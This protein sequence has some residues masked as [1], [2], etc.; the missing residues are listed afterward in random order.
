MELAEIER[1]LVDLHQAINL[2]PTLERA[3]EIGDLLI[4]AKEQIP[5]GE[6]WPWLKLHGLRPRTAW[7]YVSVARHRLANPWPATDLGIKEFFLYMRSAKK[8]EIRHE[9]QRERERLANEMGVLPDAIHLKNIDCRKFPWP[10]E[11][12]LICA[13]PP[14]HDLST[15]K[16]LAEFASKNLRESG[17]LLA[18]C[19]QPNLHDVLPILARTLTYCWCLCLSYPNTRSSTS[20]GRFECGWKP[21][22]MFYKG[23]RPALT[24]MSDTHLVVADKNSKSYH[25]WQQPTAAYQYWLSQMTTP[26]AIVA[27]PFAGSGTIAVVCQALRLTYFGTEIDRASYRVARGRILEAIKV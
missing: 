16:W 19:G 23:K 17:I 6:W 20:E 8:L 11:I 27:D 15:Y 24:K 1:R 13:D 25:E 9:R 18:Q 7:D 2:R 5:H 3:A 26:G 10:N 22:L 4:A 21:V 14:W 12:D